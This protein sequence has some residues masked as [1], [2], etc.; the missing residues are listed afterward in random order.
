[1]F[2]FIVDPR[3]L[4]IDVLTA[5]QGYMK[6]FFGC[7]TC[8]E[9][10][11]RM[12]S[13]ITPDDKTPMKAVIWLWQAHNKANAR[14][15]GDVTEDPKHPKVQFP[16]NVL[17]PQCYVSGHLAVNKTFEFLVSFYGK[18]GVIPAADDTVQ[19]NDGILNTVSAVNEMK[20]LDWWELQQRKSDLEKIRSL[21]FSKMERQKKKQERRQE[22]L[23]QRG[24]KTNQ[25][26]DNV[27]FEFDME[28][29]S[30]GYFSN[31]DMSLCMMFYMLCTLLIIVLYYYFIVKKKYRPCCGQLTLKLT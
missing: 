20:Q 29:V 16:P 19:G 28:K 9:H 23:R 15:H 4:P 3:D 11:L 31:L 22:A 18:T 30:Q 14:L 2:F 21:R 26:K 6:Y 17:C 7:R 24:T 13:L 10:F 25:N 8:V 12:A 5:I 1:M 27:D